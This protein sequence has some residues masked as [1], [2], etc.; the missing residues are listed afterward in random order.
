MQKSI[1][2]IQEYAKWFKK[3]EENE[4]IL[5][6][7]VNS[8]SP[9]LINELINQYNTERFQPVNLLRLK[10]LNSIKT[11]AIISAKDI[12]EI[13]EKIYSKD[14]LYFRE[15]NESLI[16]GLTDY[17]SKSKSPFHNWSKNFNILFPFFFTKNI[18]NEVDSLLQ[19]IVEEISGQIKVQNYISHLVN[20]FG[21]NNYGSTVCWIAAFP[22]KRVSHKKAYQLFLQ[23]NGENLIAGVNFGSDVKEDKRHLKELLGEF[24]NMNDAIIKLKDSIAIVN[25][26]NEQLMN[27]WKFS[28][29]EN[30]KHWNEFYSKG[31]MAIGWDQNEL[32]NLNNFTTT[33]DLA[34]ALG[35]GDINNSNEIWNIE[36]F[37]D[38][39]IGDVVIA[40]QGKEKVLGIGI[41]NGEYYFDSQRPFYKHVR[42][43][44]WIIN[45]RID[46]G[47]VLFRP[48]TFSPTLKWDIIKEK[49]INESPGLKEVLEK[50]GQHIT[51]GEISKEEKSDSYSFITDESKPF[52]PIAEFEDVLDSLKSKKNVIL[53]GPPGV[54]KTFIAKK[55]AYA[56]MGKIDDSKIQM[57]QFHQ[58]YSYEEFI[59]GIKPFNSDGISGFEIRKGL[60][61]NFCKK[62]QNDF[63]ND[64]FLIIDEINRGNLS[65]I[66]GELMM[67]IESDKRGEKFCIPLMY[68]G[69][70]FYVPE[71]LYLIGTMNTA[72]RSLALVDYALRRRFRFQNLKPCFDDIFI[73][74]LTDK[75][76][77]KDF[78]KEVFK[79]INALNDV[80]SNDN[81]LGPGFQIG[82]SFFCSITD[83][84]Y[85]KEK[86]WYKKIIM[87]EIKPLLEEYWFDNPQKVKDEILKLKNWEEV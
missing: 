44:D 78:I 68:S 13:K 6:Q 73:N 10:V 63:Q 61:F 87:S 7:E 27:F 71:N 58:S 81:E 14:V 20:F 36:N 77:T 76:F 22:A 45:Q 59:E 56:L 40:N 79:S 53:Q 38:A 50:I 11:G 55:I 69:E 12:V 47:K 31:I 18:K 21:P 62:A 5:F 64:Y 49:Y 70:N 16:K 32:G 33:E 41:I 1:E 35:V 86:E 9:E 65:K 4:N 37:R 39:S 42:S 46:F 25:D 74:Y 52:I 30:G 51:H 29:G 28:P 84:D 66:F 85:K 54:G 19:N 60:F 26:K 75:S 24:T 43:V 57:I 8:L 48:D 17:P 34:I 15:Y 67:L 82:H 80:I 2:K 72:D 23:I 3:L 83:E